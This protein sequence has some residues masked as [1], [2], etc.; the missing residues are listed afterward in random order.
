M[1]YVP[2]TTKNKLLPYNLYYKSRPDIVTD[3]IKIQVPL[4]LYSINQQQQ[5][6]V[7]SD[8]ESEGFESQLYAEAFNVLI[9]KFAR[10]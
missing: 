1:V 4:Q 2:Q 6:E 3:K 8:T 5:A 9:S 7:I 10:H